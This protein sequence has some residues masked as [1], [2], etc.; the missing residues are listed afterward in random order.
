MK[1]SEKIKAMVDEILTK[2]NEALEN[3]AYY[4]KQIRALRKLYELALENEKK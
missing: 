3:I 1:E 2:M 4:K